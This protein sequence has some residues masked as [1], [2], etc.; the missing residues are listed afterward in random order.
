MNSARYGTK[1]RHAFYSAFRSSEEW[2][3]PWNSLNL[4]SLPKGKLVARGGLGRAGRALAKNARAGHSQLERVE[5]TISRRA[6]CYELWLELPPPL[7][8]AENEPAN[9]EAAYGTTY[10]RV[11]ARTRWKHRVGPSSVDLRLAYP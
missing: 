5:T 3:S 9:E 1:S 8:F 4:C 10:M 7:C 11:T 2:F 6:D